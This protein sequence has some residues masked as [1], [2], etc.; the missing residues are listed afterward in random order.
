MYKGRP[1]ARYKLEIIT[2]TINF[3][4]VK[5]LMRGNKNKEIPVHI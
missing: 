3:E 1:G 4:Y 5:P 2:Y